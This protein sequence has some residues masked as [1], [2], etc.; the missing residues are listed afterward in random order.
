M[1]STLSSNFGDKLNF[2][3]FRTPELPGCRLNATP[4]SLAQ[5]AGVAATLTI[6]VIATLLIVFKVILS[7]H[8]NS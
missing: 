4:A 3:T 6:S 1:A 8:N 5:Y 2:L 7:L